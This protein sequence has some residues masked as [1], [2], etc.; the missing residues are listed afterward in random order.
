MF[1]GKTRQILCFVTLAFAL[2]L[3][4][5]ATALP[6][7][8]TSTGEL[9]NSFDVLFLPA[10]YVF[11]IWGVIYLA[12]L[13]FSLFQA[14]IRHRDDADLDRIGSAFCW[15]NVANALWL[16]FFHYELLLL[17]FLTMLA[18]LG[19]LVYIMCILHSADNQVPIWRLWFVH[20]PFGVYLGWISVATVA[21][22]TQ[23]LDRAGLSDV[24]LTD[25]GWTLV[26]FAL[27][28]ALSLFMS[29][30]LTNLPHAL[31]LIW[32]LIGIT[33]RQA[34]VQPVVIGAWI[35]VVLIALGW[36]FALVMKRSN[37]DV[38]V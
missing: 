29:L 34:D 14:R 20:I 31:V 16:F 36:V 6:L 24:I 12:V 22:A 9:A 5:M 19:L 30:R 37:P 7:G 13:A 17:S 35:S 2:A 11:S 38:P 10:G 27:I 23:L 8:G 26:T 25:V 21:N 33:V 3:N 1:R 4:W 15:T 32:A 18:L 28:V